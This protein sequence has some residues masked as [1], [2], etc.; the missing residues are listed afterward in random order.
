MEKLVSGQIPKQLYE[1][2]KRK[3]S[4]GIYRDRHVEIASCVETGRGRGEH[5]DRQLSGLL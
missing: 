5:V 2:L 3:I 1:L 4:I